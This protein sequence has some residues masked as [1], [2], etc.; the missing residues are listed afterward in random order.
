MYRERERE[1]HTYTHKLPCCSRPRPRRLSVG[2]ALPV[3]RGVSR[4]QK[5]GGEA[6]RKRRAADAKQSAVFCSVLRCQPCHLLVVR[7]VPI[8]ALLSDAV[9]MFTNG[10]E[11]N[12]FTIPP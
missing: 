1:T 9:Y 5:R 8:L 3:A 6:R 2:L 12:R 11:T 7:C 10:W 4:A